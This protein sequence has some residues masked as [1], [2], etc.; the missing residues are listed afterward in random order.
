M[1]TCECGEI[2]VDCRRGW[3][4]SVWK[5]PPECPVCGKARDTTVT[6]SV[7]DHDFPEDF[8]LENGN[9]ICT[10]CD[11]GKQFIGHKRRVACKKCEVKEAEG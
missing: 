5:Q 6:G 3:A 2:F 4:R 10:C 9:Y 11:C 1:I 7:N 8:K